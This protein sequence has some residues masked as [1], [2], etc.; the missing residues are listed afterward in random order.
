[1][2]SVFP[3]IRSANEE[4]SLLYERSKEKVA[5]FVGTD[6]DAAN[7]YQRVGF[8][9]VGKGAP[10]DCCD[11]WCEMGFHRSYVDLGHW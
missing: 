11:T 10:V 3:T 7:V 6:N 2:S 5:L 1:M 8:R 4:F 9:G